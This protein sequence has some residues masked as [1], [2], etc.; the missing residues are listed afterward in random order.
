MQGKPIIIDKLNA[1]LAHELSSMDLYLLQGR[2]FEDWG[3]RKLQEQ[4]V[5][6]SSDEREH[7]DALIQ[8]IL[9]LEGEPDV[10]TRIPLPVGKTPKEMLENDL[11]YELDVAKAL[12]EAIQLCVAEGDNASR[13]LVEKLLVDTESDHIFWLE[14]QLKLIADVGVERYLAEQL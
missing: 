3:Y 1:L 11:K 7:A 10:T 9:F 5:H 13:A 4:M 2:M 12:N 14:A 6:E 8:R